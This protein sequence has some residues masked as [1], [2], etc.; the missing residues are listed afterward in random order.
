MKNITAQDI[1]SVCNG[2][3][4]CGDKSTVITTFSRDTRTISKG[5]IYVGIKGENFNGN[6]FCKNALDAG[7]IGCITDDD[8]DN[9]IL[10]KYA[11]KIIIQ[12][13]NTVIALQKLANFKRNLYDIPVVAITG[14]VGKTSTK[15]ITASVLSKKYKVLKTQ[16][17]LNN[18]IGLPLTLLRLQDHTA[19][20]VEMGMC[21]PGEISILSKIA[22]PTIAIITNIGTAHIGN[23]GSR[24]NILKEKLDVTKGL[25]PGGTLIINNDNDLL[26]KY[27]EEEK[28]E[29]VVTYGIENKSDYNA[30]N[31]KYNKD[32]SKYDVT[33]NGKNY[34]V[35]IPI[36]GNHFVPNGL[37]GLCVGLQLGIPI[38]DILDGI[39]NFTLTKSRME[40]VNLRNNITVINDAYNASYDSMKAALKYMNEYTAQKRIAILGDMLELGEFSK[41]LHEKVGAEVAANN[42]DTLI[43]IGTEAKYIA[44]KANELGFDTSNTFSFDNNDSAIEYLK[45]NLK[46]NAVVLL[47]ASHG[48]NFAQIFDFLK[49]E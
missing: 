28:P 19:V 44:S 26:H 37:A 39:Q 10:E 17:N 2:K 27:Y 42:I 11:D 15:D 45:N 49:G 22:E 4:L 33:I 25:R 35:N 9:S 18:Q 29:N 3:L 31:I 14:S 32:S 47:K 20:V 43:T 16:G 13:E 12:V 40:I 46:E 24:E 21:Y 34:T 5:D 48:M 23:L 41:D 8:V 38:D 6:V 30:T 7:A 1:V 36:G